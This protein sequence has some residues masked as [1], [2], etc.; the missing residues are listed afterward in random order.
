MTARSH[1]DQDKFPHQACGI[2]TGGQLK[3][4]DKAIGRRFD[5]YPVEPYQG[6]SPGAGGLQFLDHRSVDMTP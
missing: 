5:M 2:A 6:G 3:G 1:I 4:K